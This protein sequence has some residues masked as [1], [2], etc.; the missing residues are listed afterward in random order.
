MAELIGIAGISAYLSIFLGPFFTGLL[1]DAFGS[2]RPIFA[3]AA[4]CHA[5]GLVLLQRVKV[6]S[7]YAKA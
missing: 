7:T 3:F 4:A 5:I 6:K 2:Y 1:I